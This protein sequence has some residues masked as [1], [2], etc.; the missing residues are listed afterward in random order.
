MA[1]HVN[2]SS[3]ASSKSAMSSKRRVR[4]GA[5]LL[6]GSSLL[7]LT[8]FGVAAGC[9]ATSVQVIDTRD[10][11]AGSAPGSDLPVV[12][13]DQ[14]GGA[15]S[16]FGTSPGQT[17]A[18][19][20]DGCPAGVCVVDARN[21]LTL[22]C[23][24][25]CDKVQCPPGWLCQAADHGVARACFRDPDAPAADP[26]AGTSSPVAFTD[27]KLLGY[28]ANT[29]ASSMLALSDF[30]DPAA[31]N[32][33]LVIVVIG[34]IWDA[35]GNKQLADLQTSTI[36]RV[37]WVGLLINGDKPDGPAAASDLASWHS[38]YPATNLLL[39]SKMEKLGSGFGVPEALPTVIAL[40]VRTLK[41]VGRDVGYRAPDALKNAVDAWRAKAK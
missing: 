34:S 5:I 40:D 12:S 36:P 21:D 28:R 17:A 4:E 10:G 16:G 11:S 33:D 2:A 27:Q 1:L 41:E 9:T 35:F 25:D 7:A 23:S 14:L 3:R 18:F 29:S 20:T 39:D 24:A 26:D 19:S 37:T 13:A 30:R 38:Q 6:L 15:C 32:S 22:F 8:A 31:A